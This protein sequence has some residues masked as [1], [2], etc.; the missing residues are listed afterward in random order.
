MHQDVAGKVIAILA[1]L[2]KLAPETITLES[3]LEQLGV[4]SLDK[5]NLLFELESAFNIDIP[6]EEARS[7][8][9]VGEMVQKLE[10]IVSAPDAAKGA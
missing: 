4:D 9:T 10:A 6:D 8:R 1:S 3:S 7:I 5:I 2:K